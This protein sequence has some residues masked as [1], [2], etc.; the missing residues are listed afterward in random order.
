MI[1]QVRTFLR[2]GLPLPALS[3]FS[4]RIFSGETAVR[5]PLLLAGHNLS[6]VKR[7]KALDE[8]GI[9]E[10]LSWEDILST[11]QADNPNLFSKRK[12]QTL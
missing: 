9:P 12:L 2:R 5:R 1:L 7:L 8:N 3:K 10:I 4:K 11:E 6:Y